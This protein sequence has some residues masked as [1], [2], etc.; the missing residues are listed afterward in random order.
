MDALEAI[1]SRRSIR[2]YTPTP[3]SAEELHSV[4]DAAMNAP[5]SSNG[6]P[7]HFVVIDER[8]VLDEIPKFHPYSNMLKEAP[9]AV[10]VCGDTTLEKTKGVWVQDCSAA[11][12]NILLGA[13]AQ[14]L[15]SVWLGVFPIEE[16]MAGLKKLLGL[17]DNVIPLSIIALG[18]PAEAKPPANRFNA[19][20]VHRN[21]W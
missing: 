4:L 13:R 15:G 2:K 1:L 20:R 17:P 18:Y 16:R 8:K 14:G 10:V 6:Q 9:M 21:R 5:S 19:G 3:V 7:W 11:T 12:E